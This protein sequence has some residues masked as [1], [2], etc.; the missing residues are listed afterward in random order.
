MLLRGTRGT[1]HAADAEVNG[2]AIIVFFP[3]KNLRPVVKQIG[4]SLDVTVC[5]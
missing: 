4:D 3:Y 5:V 2:R 1:H